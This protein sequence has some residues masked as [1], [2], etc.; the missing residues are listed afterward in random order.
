MINIILENQAWDNVAE[1]TE[2]LLEK[3]CVA[4]GVLALAG[5]V[6]AE[7]VL[8]K[9]AYDIVAPSAGTISQILIEKDA[10]FKRGQVLA[11]FVEA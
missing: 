4:T 3:W 2:A 9:T 6:L 7:V 1:G 10:T 8:I 11:T 5:Q